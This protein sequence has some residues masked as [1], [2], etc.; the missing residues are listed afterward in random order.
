M[1]YEIGATDWFYGYVLKVLYRGIIHKSCL[2]V[3]F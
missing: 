1:P 3:L 2:N